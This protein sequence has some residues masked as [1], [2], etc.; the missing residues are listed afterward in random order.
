MSPADKATGWLADLAARL[1]ED[2][3][4][5]EW[6]AKL[7]GEEL[8]R[9]SAEPGLPVMAFL[10]VCIDRAYTALETGFS[11]VARLVDENSP[12]GEDWHKAL[13]HQ[14][15]LA[16]Q[17]RRPAILAPETAAQLDRLRRHRHWLRH[18]YAAAFDWRRMEHAAR[19]LAP[20]IQ[21][22][23]ADVERFVAYIEKS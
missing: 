16:I 5:A 12:G 9:L 7:A 3:S 11:R 2:V 14:M 4:A 10:S 21:A 19:A 8:S 22:A 13:L 1:R 20:S 6:Q 23:R 18:A 17:D 15:T